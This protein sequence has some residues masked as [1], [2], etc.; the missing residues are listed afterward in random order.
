MEFG[1][2]LYAYKSFTKG[3]KDSGVSFAE[4]ECTGWGLGGGIGLPRS[5][6]VRLLKDLTEWVIWS[7]YPVPKVTALVPLLYNF[8]PTGRNIFGNRRGAGVKY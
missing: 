5:T 2:V 6:C 1:V 3:V 8:W 7:R 4:E